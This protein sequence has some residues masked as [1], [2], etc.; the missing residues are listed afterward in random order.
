MTML[1]IRSCLLH[2]PISERDSANASFYCYYIG[3]AM[4]PYAEGKT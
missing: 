2:F 3:Q 1:R 4:L